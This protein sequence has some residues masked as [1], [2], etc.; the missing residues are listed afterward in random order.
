MICGPFF[1]QDKLNVEFIEV[2]SAILE[3]KFA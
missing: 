2:D 3:D 1:I